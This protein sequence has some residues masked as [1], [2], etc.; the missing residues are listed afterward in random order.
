MQK[1]KKEKE[2]EKEGLI[3]RILQQD[4][5]P[6]ELFRRGQRMSPDEELH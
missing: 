3:Q 2:K 1:K 5:S 6:C 4:I